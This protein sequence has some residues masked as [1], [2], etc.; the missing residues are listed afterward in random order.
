MVVLV[1]GQTRV[2]FAMSRD[3]LMPR[4][5]T[6]TGPHGTPVRVTLIVGAPVAV[7]ASVFPIDKLEEMVNIGTLFA[8]VLVSA[9][10]MCRCRRRP[11]TTW[12]T[13]WPG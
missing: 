12:P 5:L 4:S 3:R 13:T 7:M 10:V 9:S 6:K 8:F 1:L 2:L 11:I